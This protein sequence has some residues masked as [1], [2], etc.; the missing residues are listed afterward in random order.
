M[1][2]RTSL[3]QSFF[4]TYGKGTE[5]YCLTFPISN[6]N[7]TKSDSYVFDILIVVVL[8]QQSILKRAL[9]CSIIITVPR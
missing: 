7:S 1:H 3:L 6:E 5:R 2:N 4:V 9:S 8:P